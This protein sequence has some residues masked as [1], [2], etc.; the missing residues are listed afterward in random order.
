MTDKN[1]KGGIGIG[2]GVVAGA[3]ALAAGYYFYMSKDAK[4]HR[5]IMTDWAHNFKAEAIKEMGKVKKL[6]REPIIKAIDKAAKMYAVAQNVDKNEI[7][8]AAK[9]LKDNWKT[10]LDE[11]KMSAKTSATSAKKTVKKSVAKAKSK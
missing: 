10:L 3:A 8:A 6:N 9:E 7:V 5:K 1:T 2:T 4:K 11:V